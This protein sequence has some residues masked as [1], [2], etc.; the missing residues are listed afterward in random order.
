MQLPLNRQRRI[1]VQQA[2]EPIFL[3]EHQGV[4]KKHASGKR[5]GGS[6]LARIITP[7]NWL[8]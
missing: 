3:A 2:R 7:R 1:V 4:G 8:I 6:Q 5:A